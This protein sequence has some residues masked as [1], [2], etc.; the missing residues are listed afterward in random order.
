MKHEW[1]CERFSLRKCSLK[2]LS[3]KY[4]LLIRWCF[5]MRTISYKQI[6]VR[7]V[8][9]KTLTFTV[10]NQVLVEVLLEPTEPC[11]KATKQARW[12][13]DTRK[14]IH[15]VPFSL[16]WRNQITCIAIVCSTVCSGRSKKAS[17]L[18]VTGLCEGNLPETDAFPSQR[19]NNAENVSIW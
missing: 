7:I 19:A 1:K 14:L 4:R 8:L 2:I 12:P 15:D 17:K 6:V 16:Q 3:T 5:S 11:W 9:L 18:C 13:I 10:H